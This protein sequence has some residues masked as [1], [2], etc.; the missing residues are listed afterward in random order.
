MRALVLVD[1]L[2]LVPQYGTKT[3]VLIRSQER[4]TKEQA[5]HA[6]FAGRIEAGLTTLARQGGPAG[7]DSATGG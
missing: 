7:P 2:G 1:L 4:R 5:I 6:R 3:F